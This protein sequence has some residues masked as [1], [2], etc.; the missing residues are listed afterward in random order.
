MDKWELVDITLGQL[1]EQWKVDREAFEMGEE[2]YMELKIRWTPKFDKV[3]DS[4]I[5]PKAIAC[6]YSKSS[7]EMSCAIFNFD[8]DGRVATNPAVVVKVSSYFM[9]FRPAYR[10]FQW[11]IKQILIREKEREQQRFMR[12]LLKVFPGTMDEYILGKDK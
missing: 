9:F 5:T 10:K 2:G 1:I 12:E 11:L 4:M 7:G 3:T 6:K 8:G